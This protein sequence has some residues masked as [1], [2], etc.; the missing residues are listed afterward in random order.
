M[1]TRRQTFGD[2]EGFKDEG[3]VVQGRR[4]EN[5]KNILFVCTSISK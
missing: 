1:T 2:R 3:K 5:N 4:D